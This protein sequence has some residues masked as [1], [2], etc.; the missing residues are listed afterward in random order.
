MEFHGNL[1]IEGKLKK[2]IDKKYNEIF[3]NPFGNGKIYKS[4]NIARWTFEGKLELLGKEP[5]YNTQQEP[6]K[7]KQK[8]LNSSVKQN[9]DF[10]KTYDYSK[11]DRVLERNSTQNFK[12]I[13]K[14]E[15]RK[16]FAYSV[17]L[18]ILEHIWLMN[19]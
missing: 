1:Y 10:L 14:T 2:D 4:N 13:S 8:P 11:V 5:V 15:I 17:E 3:D 16:Y 9:Y 12:T 19:F 6:L 18:D 7:V